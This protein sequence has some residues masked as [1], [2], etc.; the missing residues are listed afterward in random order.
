MAPQKKAA[1]RTAR[2]SGFLG[3]QRSTVGVLAMVVLGGL[4]ERSLSL[5]LVRSVAA[6]TVMAVAVLGFLAV[7]SESHMII[8]VVG[9]LIVGGGTYLLA[10]LLLRS[11][12]I[13]RLPGLLLK[14]GE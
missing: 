14:R 5:S 1:S 8:L 3:L 2:I 13:R 12:E 10:A 7:F 4:G 6:S 9:G 11:R